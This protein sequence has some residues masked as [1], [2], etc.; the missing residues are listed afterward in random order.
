[1]GKREC[2]LH[3]LDLDRE[4]VA[5]LVGQDVPADIA[6]CCLRP[7]LTASSPAS[8]V[9]MLCELMSEDDVVEAGQALSEWYRF[10][11]HRDS[12][13]QAARRALNGGCLRAVAPLLFHLG[14]I[15]FPEVSA[16][17][18]DPAADP[19]G[20]CALLRGLGPE[21]QPLFVEHSRS[22]Q[23]DIR[24]CACA[25]LYPDQ[26]R[27]QLTELAASVEKWPDEERAKH[28][29]DF[30]RY[31]A[32]TRL[33]A[34][35]YLDYLARA[36][37]RSSDYAA[38]AR[39]KRE[40]LRRWGPLPEPDPDPWCPP[41]REPES[42]EAELGLD[43]SQLKWVLRSLYDAERRA[44]G[45]SQDTYEL[46]TKNRGAQSSALLDSLRRADAALKANP[47]DQAQ[48]HLRDQL[49]DFYDIV[50]WVR[51]RFPNSLLG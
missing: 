25:G 41:A 6:A 29:R 28:I 24:I 19:A 35:D 3:W 7:H 51:A 2:I 5:R 15:I 4:L 47:P 22:P 36:S 49:A 9:R 48:Q 40:I 33:A 14:P 26:R 44:N 13:L 37:G 17:L 32:P 10:P 50:A 34:L 46:L 43:E 1:M 45:L 42:L 27:Q 21:G 20:C 18:A 23:P 31:D 30:G 16:V 8:A 12:I 39:C 38:V 11:E